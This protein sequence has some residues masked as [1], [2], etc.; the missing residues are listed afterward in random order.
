MDMLEDEED[1]EPITKS[2]SSP[3]KLPNKNFSDQLISKRSNNLD[4]EQYQTRKRYRFDEY[5]RIPARRG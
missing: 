2:L 5:D 3:I 1:S 4:D